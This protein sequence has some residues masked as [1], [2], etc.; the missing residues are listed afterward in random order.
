VNLQT[1]E[2]DFASAHLFTPIVSGS[3]RLSK[4]TTNIVRTTP[5]LERPNPKRK[6]SDKASFFPGL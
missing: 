2:Q 3:N 6:H 4:F 1:F 5:S